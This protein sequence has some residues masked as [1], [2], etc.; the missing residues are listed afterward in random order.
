MKQAL[1]SFCGLALA[2][3]AGKSLLGYTAVYNIAY[4]A[5]AAMAFVVAFT[6]LWLWWVR[7]TPLALG[8]AFSWLGAGGVIGWWWIY[9]LANAPVWM[10]Q[11]PALF[12]FLAAYL[13][14]AFQHFTVMRQTMAV[15]AVAYWL[16]LLGLLLG[17]VGLAFG[18]Q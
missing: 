12:L 9:S 1:L 13:V 17:V 7:A 11:N 3:F 8:M 2:F 6:F 15:N 10:H 16:G 18:A 5:L 14:G 4:G